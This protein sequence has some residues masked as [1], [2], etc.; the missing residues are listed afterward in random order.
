MYKF[1]ELKPP[2]KEKKTKTPFYNSLNINYLY[3]YSIR[4]YKYAA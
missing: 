3:N 2:K 1:K 4:F